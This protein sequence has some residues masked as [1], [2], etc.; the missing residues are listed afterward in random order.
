MSGSVATD[1]HSG[2]WPQP[3]A[4][5]LR[6]MVVY[7]LLIWLGW[8]YAQPLAEAMLPLFRTFLE[9]LDARLQIVDFSVGHIG[10]D[11][12]PSPDLL[13]RL[14]VTVIRPIVIGTNVLMPVKGGWLASSTT[15]GNALQSLIL[16]I[17]LIL[18]WPARQGIEYARR[19]LIGLPL[20]LAMLMLDVPLTLWAYIWDAPLRHYDPQGF[21]PLLTWARFLTNGGRLMLGLLIAWVIIYLA[22]LPIVRG[23][24]SEPPLR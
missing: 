11:R 4:L 6:C 19:A 14:E 2:F 10:G 3:L 1:N 22:L 7:A 24:Q 13:F 23:P 5:A 8:R 12:K 20:M 16:A 9:A 18:A 21:S 15:V 17:G